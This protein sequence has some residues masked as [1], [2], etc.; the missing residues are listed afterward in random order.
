MLKK[1]TDGPLQ[2][3]SLLNSTQLA[4]FNPGFDKPSNTIYYSNQVKLLDSLQD[5]IS[6]GGTMIAL[7]DRNLAVKSKILIDQLIN[8][9]FD[10]LSMYEKS[11]TRSYTDKD[12]IIVESKTKIAQ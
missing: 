12:L 4:D 3:A 10:G 7:K 5:L 11:A 8:P 1:V 9:I 6:W 2:D